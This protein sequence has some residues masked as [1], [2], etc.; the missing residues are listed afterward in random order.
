[1][2]QEGMS[3]SYTFEKLHFPD[4]AYSEGPTRRENGEN[5]E[6]KSLYKD[7]TCY[8]CKEKGHI[9]TECQKKQKPKGNGG[10]LCKMA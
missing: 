6:K 1:M 3:K 9:S 5:S 7:L 2:T 8:N 10:G 4:K